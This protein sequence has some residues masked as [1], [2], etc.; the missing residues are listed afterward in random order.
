MQLAGACLD[1]Q[2]HEL[3]T[4]IYGASLNQKQGGAGGNEGIEVGHGAISPDER[5]WVKIRVERYTIELGTGKAKQC[6]FAPTLR[7]RQ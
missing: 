5:A 1:G 4:G 2:T 6:Q 7:R 3:P